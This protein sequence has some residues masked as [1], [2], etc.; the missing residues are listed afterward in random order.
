MVCLMEK[1]PDIAKGFAIGKQEV[2]RD[3]K[4]A[5][6]TKWTNNKNN[7]LATGGGDSTECSLSELEEQVATLLC[8]STAD[9]GHNGNCFGMAVATTPATT[10]LAASTSCPVLSEPTLSNNTLHTLVE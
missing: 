6:K 2:W 9:E 7:L 1:R 8:Y 10:N 5:T 4:Y 3:F